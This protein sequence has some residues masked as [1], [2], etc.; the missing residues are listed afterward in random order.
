LQNYFIV[1]FGAGIGGMVR[2][3]GTNFVYKFLSP[4]FPYGTLFVNVLGSFIIGIVMYYLDS[5]DLISHDLRIFLTVGFCGG[6]TTFSTF[7][8]ETINFLKEN[9]FLFAG[10]N[11][12]SNV[13]ITLL[14][15]FVAYK[16]SKLLSGV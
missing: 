5:N 9:D 15:L 14:A 4:S 2:Y 10:L 7:S 6:L 16:L 13:L 8:Y 3:W 1:F 12:I 11:I